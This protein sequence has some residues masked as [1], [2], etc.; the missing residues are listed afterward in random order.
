MPKAVGTRGARDTGHTAAATP[1]PKSKASSGRAAK[2][3]SRPVTPATPAVTAGVPRNQSSASLR[4]DSEPKSRIT[5]SR[6]QSVG[7]ASMANAA[8]ADADAAVPADSEQPQR[9]RHSASAAAAPAA[10]P[11]VV[12]LCGTSSDRGAGDAATAEESGSEAAASSDEDTPVTRELPNRCLF[13]AQ[14]PQGCCNNAAVS[15]GVHFL[16]E[17][18]RCRTSSRAA[19]IVSTTRRIARLA[20]ARATS[21]ALADADAA[22]VSGDSSGSEYELPAGGAGASDDEASVMDLTQDGEGDLQE[23]LQGLVRL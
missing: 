19:A 11:E 15:S 8:A 9:L 17:C 20:A 2:G 16:G 18:W 14:R 6:S 21:A 1:A 23:E 4:A 5:R 12:D 7:M 22:Q 13:C 10:E 3:D